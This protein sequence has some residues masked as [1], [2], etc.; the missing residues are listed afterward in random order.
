MEQG[1][2]QRAGNMS[3]VASVAAGVAFIGFES[4]HCCT[5]IPLTVL[6]RDPLRDERGEATAY[7]SRIQIFSIFAS[8]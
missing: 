1:L 6:H 7:D 2:G 5:G 4:V 8:S 3:P